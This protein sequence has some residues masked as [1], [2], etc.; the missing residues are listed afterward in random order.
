MLFAAHSGIR[1][2]VLAA[3]LVAVA[4][5]VIGIANT[6]RTRPKR[7]AGAAFVG[8]LD[9]QVVLGVLVLLTRTFYGQLLGHVILMLLA[10][11]TAHGFALVH[12]SRAP[13]QRRRGFMLVGYVIVF[14]L[15]FAG[16]KAIG[17]PLL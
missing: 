4:V 1:Y 3:W 11:F 17:R 15:V 7:L 6:D 2:L 5:E 13:E 16:I 14:F 10:A 8:I 12:R 9:V